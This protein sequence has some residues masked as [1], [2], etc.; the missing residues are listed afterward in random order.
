MRSHRANDNP[1][2]KLSR[3]TNDTALY[4]LRK[5]IS[6][7]NNLAKWCVLY[8]V[9]VLLLFHHL[10]LTHNYF[11][12]LARGTL[13]TVQAIDTIPQRQEREKKTIRRGKIEKYSTE[14]SWSS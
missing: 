1:G 9:I 4:S 3:Q 14:L 8:A 10:L 7:K 13:F 6:H 5:V 12:R 2:Q 11:N